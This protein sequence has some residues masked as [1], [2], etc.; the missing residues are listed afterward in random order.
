LDKHLDVAKRAALQAGQFLLGNLGGTK[1]IHYKSEGHENPSSSAD[2]EAE[3]II[4]NILGSNFPEYGSISEERGEKS[5]SSDY[6]WLIDPLD[7]TVNFIHGVRYFAVSIALAYR[8]DVILGVVY[9]P[10]ADEM[11]AAVKGDGA[12][13]NGERIQV[14]TIG[15]VDESLLAI[16]FP[17]DRNSESFSKVIKYF[18]RLA[19]DSQ[20]VRRDGSTAL[21]LC[22]VACGRYDG[23]CVAGNEVWDYAAGNLIVAKAGGKVT[24]FAGEYFGVKN[25]K[26]QVL[27]TNG[28]IHQAILKC[29]EEEEAPR[30]LQP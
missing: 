20:A 7:G 5:G 23:F 28:K 25:S 13:A 9:N 12:Y 27:A 6:T 15:R 18:I 22:N 3:G 10:V 8:D 2:E 24:D 1:G 16:G 21:A 11:F 30:I 19:K 4:L 14:S 29:F 17:Y 26:S